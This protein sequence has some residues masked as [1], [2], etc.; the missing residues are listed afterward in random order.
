MDLILWRHAEAEEGHPDEKRALTPRGKRQAARV[1]Q[2]L[3]G[4]LEE[5]YGILVSPAL[6]TQQTAEALDLPFETC[7]A[8][9]TR[10]T[11]EALLEAVQWPLAERTVVVV[12]H[13][14]TLGETAALLMTGHV[15]PWSVRK[16]ALWWF[17]WRTRR[18]QAQVVLRAVLN[19]DLL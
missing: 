7:A 5:P 16:G 8:V 12:G 1:A 19:P 2:W 18:D 17:S 13:Q 6:R 14:P 3:S 11:P 10:S 4:V 9:G 15:Q